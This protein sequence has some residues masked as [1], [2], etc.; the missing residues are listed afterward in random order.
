MDDRRIGSE[1]LVVAMVK[2]QTAGMRV[3]SFY[4]GLRT[5]AWD[6]IQIVSATVDGRMLGTRVD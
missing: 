6:S 3:N 1:S 4:V 5:D 2:G